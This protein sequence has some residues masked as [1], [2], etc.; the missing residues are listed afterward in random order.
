MQKNDTGPGLR[1]L[2]VEDEPLIG[3]LLE[4]MIT[5]LG[6]V[7]VGP[8][9]SLEDALAAARLDNFDVALVDLNLRGERTDEVATLLAKRGIPF[10]V[11]S[12]NSEA[13]LYL[14]Q[15]MVVQKPF[16]LDDIAAALQGLA[17]ACGHG[18]G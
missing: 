12:G 17:S 13:G 8:F 7:F 5:E 4:D 18:Q 1:V 2:V 16:G 10:A 9:A 11:A 15:T 6:A 3:I 14:G